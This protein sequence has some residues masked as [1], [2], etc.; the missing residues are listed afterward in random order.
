[1]KKGY[2]N[3]V[4]LKSVIKAS[5]L[6]MREI[7]LRAHVSESYVKLLVSGKLNSPTIDKFIQ[8]CEVLKVSPHILVP[9][10]EKLNSGNIDEQALEQALLEV[11]ETSKSVDSLTAKQKSQLAISRYKQ[12]LGNK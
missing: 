8:I 1:M 7:S 2:L 5:G 11:F 6:S 4:K 10:L 12:I 3:R 9:D